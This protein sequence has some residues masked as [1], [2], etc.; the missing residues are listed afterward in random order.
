M[1]LIVT[2]RLT[3]LSE[4]TLC[5]TQHNDTQYHNAQHHNIQNTVIMLCVILYCFPCSVLNLYD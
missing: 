4:L 2:L 5:D 1:D 3:K